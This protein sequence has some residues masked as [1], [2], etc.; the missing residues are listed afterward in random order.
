MLKINIQSA[1]C[2]QYKVDN[3]L[4]GNWRY[5]QPVES[6]ATSAVKIKLFC[7]CGLPVT[8]ALRISGIE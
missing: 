5:S 4:F 2:R 6:K 3:N 7:P 1:V 8:R